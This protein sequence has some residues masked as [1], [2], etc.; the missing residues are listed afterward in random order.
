MYNK[1]CQCSHVILEINPSDVNLNRTGDD[2]LQGCFMASFNQNNFVLFCIYIY[3][4]PVSKLLII[5]SLEKIAV[6][7]M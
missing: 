4:Q 5:F 3:K 2:T 1:Y 7:P 6:F